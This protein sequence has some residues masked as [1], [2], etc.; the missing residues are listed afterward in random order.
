MTERFE[1]PWVSEEV[2]AGLAEAAKEAE[3]KRKLAE[4]CKKCREKRAEKRA[5]AQKRYQDKNKE[6][7]RERQ[8]RYYQENKKKI[9]KN[10]NHNIYV[11]SLVRSAK[12]RAKKSGIPFNITPDDV[13]IPELCPYLGIP[14]TKGEGVF[15]ANSPSLDRVLPTLGYVKENVRVISYKANS[16]KRDAT[17]EELR[18]FAI[19]I[20]RYH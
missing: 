20:L 18:L 12:C 11:K 19:N 1:I 5:K 2:T 13:V 8:K 16:M 3:R 6:K 7:S 9:G 4:A 17:T 15:H 14:L 10:L